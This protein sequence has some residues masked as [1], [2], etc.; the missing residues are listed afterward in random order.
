MSQS[1]VGFCAIVWLVERVNPTLSVRYRQF[2]LVSQIMPFLLYV[3][4]TV[5]LL[6]VFGFFYLFFFYCHLCIILWP[7]IASLEKQSLWYLLH[8][9]GTVDVNVCT[10]YSTFINTCWVL[11]R[12]EKN[13]G[14]LNRS[15]IFLCKK[16]RENI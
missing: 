3:P 4:C 15:I 10:L 5:V 14:I 1:V 16:K 6:Y 8:S 12:G 2:S 13:R 9:V 7:C 11:F